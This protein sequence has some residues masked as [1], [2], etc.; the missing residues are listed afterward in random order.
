MV[1]LRDG[2]KQT[3]ED[4]KKKVLKLQWLLDIKCLF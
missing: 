3:A 4:E 2:S 1:S